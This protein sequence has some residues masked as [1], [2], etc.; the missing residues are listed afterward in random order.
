VLRECKKGVNLA[1]DMKHTKLKPNFFKRPT[2][3]VARKLLGK[4]LVVKKGKNMLSG[5]IVETEAY[6]GEDDLACHASKGRTQRSETLY[7]KAGTVYVYLIYGM[8]S[9]FNIVTEKEEFPSAVLVR[10]VEPIEGVKVMKQ[11]RKTDILHNLTSGPG[12]LC[13][14]F[15][16]DREMNGMS[17]FGKDIWIEDRGDVVKNTDVKKAKRIGVEYAGKCRNHLWRFYMK[18]NDFISRVF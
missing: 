7:K 13:K 17:V 6:I 11:K 14:A 16:I 8:Y 9:C 3:D 2:L 5:K 4:Y 10:A 18:Q 12:K 15:D 1:I